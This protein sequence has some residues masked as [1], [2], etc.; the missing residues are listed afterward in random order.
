MGRLDS[1]YRSELSDYLQPSVADALFQFTDVG[2]V[3]IGFISEG[4]LRNTP[5][6]AQAAQIGSKDLAQIHAQAKPLVVY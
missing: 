1:Q 2:A 4:F 6:M 3:Y 5:L